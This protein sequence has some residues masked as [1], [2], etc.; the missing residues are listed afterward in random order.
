MKQILQ[1]LFI[2]ILISFSISGYAG[3]ARASLKSQQASFSGIKMFSSYIIAANGNVADGNRCVFAPQYSNAV[4]GYDAIKISN[5]G[6]NFGLV[7]DTKTLAVEARQPISNDTLFFK[8]FNLIPQTYKLM[9]APQNLEGTLSYAE[10]IDRYTNTRKLISLVD[11]TYAIAEVTTD[12]ASKASDRFIIVFTPMAS[13]GALPVKFTGISAQKSLNYVSINWNVQTE[14]QLNR[15]EIE[16]SSDGI[17]YNKIGVVLPGRINGAYQFNDLQP[18]TSTAYY[19]IK[20]VDNDGKVLLS[21]IAKSMAVSISLKPTMSVY[22]NPVIND[23]LQLNLT[24]LQAGTYILQLTNSLGAV[25]YQTKV[26]VNS[27]SL[28][29][30]ISFTNY[31]AKGSY[32]LSIINEEGKRISQSL[33]IQ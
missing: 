16:R 32:S 25:K 30:T 2:G 33:V 1:F 6:E 22:P 9:F 7:R 11:T 5:P 15:Y 13:A 3:D 20:A 19:R 21:N 4:D 8:M 12:A 29:K 23:N 27:S 14:L 26:V 24:N 31:M 28:N 10:L 18:L 17:N